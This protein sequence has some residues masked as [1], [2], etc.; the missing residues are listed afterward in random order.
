MNL[1]DTNTVIGAASPNNVA[2]ATRVVA[3]PYANSVV[4]RIEAL[5]FHRISPEDK[6]DLEAF[7]SG[8]AQLSLD[9]EIAEKAVQLRQERRMSLGDSII[10]ATALIRDLPLWTRNVSDFKHIVGLELR[11]PFSDES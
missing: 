5:G 10:A 8:G 9:A 7:L 2:L 11:D 6:A 1:L 3:A 4:T